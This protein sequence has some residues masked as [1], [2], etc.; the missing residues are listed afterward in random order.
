MAV[1][2]SRTML[3]AAAECGGIRRVEAAAATA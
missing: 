1:S 2:R 3:A